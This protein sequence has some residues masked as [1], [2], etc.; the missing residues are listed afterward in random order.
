MNQDFL[1]DDTS[2]ITKAQSGSSTG[3]PDK[4]A[5]LSDASETQN[6]KNTA[7]GTNND[8]I[9]NI[10]GTLFRWTE[11]SAEWYE[12]ASEYTG[13]HDRLTEII[14]PHL[15][16]AYTCCELACGTGTLARHL[17]PYVHS[18]TA[19]DIDYHATD[20]LAGMIA[21]G[22]CPNLSII[23]GDWHEV[24][25]ESSFNAAVFSFFGAVEQ[26]WDNLKKL[27]TDRVV[28][29]SPRSRTGKMK[30]AAEA[31]ESR[32][33]S[34]SEKAPDEVSA[35]TI[36]EESAGS[37]EPAASDPQKPQRIIRG[38][39]RSFE[40]G[41]SIASFLDKKEISYTRKDVDLEFGQPFKNLS[42]ARDYARYYYRL[43]ERE[44]DI[45]LEKKLIR[46]DSGGWYF[47]KTKELTIIII[48]MTTVK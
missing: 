6:T 17:A 11:D 4:A 40:T 15:S 42:Q 46:L 20:H 33:A 28:V 44:I 2:D 26:D 37:P 23:T 29:I 22:S 12:A 47:P 18:Y 35:V 30:L 9:K 13:Y 48:D 25:S 45:F 39:V 14:A 34:G 31:Y 16:D 5:A 7:V 21:D 27:A 41:P 36:S 3:S 8:N 24:F 1:H 19:N 10:K 32:P 43:D 38:K